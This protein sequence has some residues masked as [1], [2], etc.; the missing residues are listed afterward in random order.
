MGRP[1]PTH[2]L[3]QDKKLQNPLRIRR[4]A[5]DHVLNCASTVTK[6]GEQENQREREVKKKR[7]TNQQFNKLRNS[8][9]IK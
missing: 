8:L 4:N 1:H 3:F 6:I 5:L 7:S 9:E 2:T